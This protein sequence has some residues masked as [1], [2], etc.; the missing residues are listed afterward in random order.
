MYVVP[1]ED[2][3]ILLIGNDGSESKYK[4]YEVF[5]ESTSYYFI[6]R[7]IVSKFNECF[8]N[9][10]WLLSRLCAK[11]PLPTLYIVRDKFG[12]FYSKD[13]ILYDKKEYNG[14]YFGNL[15]LK[16]FGPDNYIYRYDPVPH[17]GNHRWKFGRWYKRPKT[18]QERRWNEAYKG[19]V[20]GKRRGKYLIDAW[21]DYPRSDCFI[22]RSWKKN[23]K[24]KQWM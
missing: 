24:K 1:Q 2:I 4:N 3:E 16:L 6:E 9:L 22:K 21:D 5:I 13:R 19:Y 17:T 10:D 15:R 14:K 20:R 7:Q 8:D 18:T 11:K 23:K 12:G